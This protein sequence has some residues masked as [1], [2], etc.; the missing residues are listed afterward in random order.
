MILYYKDINQNQRQIRSTA[1]DAAFD[2]SRKSSKKKSSRDSEC[3]DSEN[4]SDF[5]QNVSETSSGTSSNEFS[6]VHNP[7]PSDH[8]IIKQLQNE[9]LYEFIDRK[10]LPDFLGGLADINYRNCPLLCLPAEQILKE[11]FNYTDQQIA[12]TLKPFRSIIEKTHQLK[13]AFDKKMYAYQWNSLE[14]ARQIVIGY[15]QDQQKSRLVESS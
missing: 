7:H 8:E 12:K 6:T 10:N 9:A 13:N 11:R 5:E 1:P 15:I 3:D 14:Q 2:S 4:S